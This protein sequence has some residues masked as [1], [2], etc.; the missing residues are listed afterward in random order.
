MV[1]FFL[2]ARSARRLRPSAARASRAKEKGDH[3]ITWAHWGPRSEGNVERSRA[4]RQACY[5]VR[6]LS[7][8]R[9]HR[10]AV[11]VLQINESLSHV[12]PKYG[13]FCLRQNAL[14]LESRAAR[15]AGQAMSGKRD[16]AT[17]CRAARLFSTFP[18][19]Q[20]LGTP[21]K[22]RHDSLVDLTRALRARPPEVAALQPRAQRA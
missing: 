8:S 5:D 16:P 2:R 17:A 21:S 22:R 11:L 13:A 4:A 3:I 10:T 9:A 7:L 18:S 14:T 19:D 15:V 1:P 6:I 20:S 12:G